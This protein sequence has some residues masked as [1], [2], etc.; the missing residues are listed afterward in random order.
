[1]ISSTTALSESSRHAILSS[2]ERVRAKRVRAKR[3]VPLPESTAQ[4]LLFFL[5]SLKGSIAFS[6]T[7]R[8]QEYQ[9]RPHR[10]IPR[11]TTS[12][13]KQNRPREGLQY[14]PS[15]GRT[16]QPR[17][18]QRQRADRQANCR[19]FDTT[20]RSGRS[21]SAEGR[22]VTRGDRLPPSRDGTNS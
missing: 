19:Q 1:M 20:Q 13:P 14:A 16:R 2:S 5:P 17:R 15:G 11:G 6:S 21:V 8:L 4:T 3:G 7:M 10:T 18:D 22:S 9:N 12:S